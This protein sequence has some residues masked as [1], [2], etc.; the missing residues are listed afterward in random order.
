MSKESTNY[1]NSPKKVYIRTFGCQMNV[2]DSDAV[3]G[4]L[5]EQGYE[6]TYSEKD[7]DVI[8]YNT[9]SVRQHAEDRVWSNVGMLAKKR[10]SPDAGGRRPI[11]GIIGCMAQRNKADIFKRLPH[12]SFIAGPGDIADVP[13]L[14]AESGRPKSY[15]ASVSLQKRPEKLY[16]SPYRKDKKKAYVNISEGCDNYCSYCIVPY[17]R[18]PQRDRSH[19]AVIAEVEHLIQNGFKEITLLGQNVN[20]YKGGVSFVELL[21]K[22]NSLEGLKSVS[23]ITSHPKDASEELFAAMAKLDKVAKNLHLPIQSGSD[24]I[25]KLMNRGYT[26]SKYLELADSYRK[27]VKGGGLT[28]DIIVGFPGESEEDFKVTLN[29]M[30]KIKFDA[31]YIFKYS[32]RPGTAA[33]KLKDDVPVKEKQKRHRVLLDLQKALWQ[34]KKK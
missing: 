30:K 26:S 28:T 15:A 10:R 21:E 19:D 9:C 2:R 6:L 33:D 8:I 23:F 25:L 34:E 31:A 24:R 16:K 11:I 3:T 17:V 7:A 14:I 13:K 5:L 20:S 18:G 1:K 22:I 29:I 12:V 32:P 4:M 27:L